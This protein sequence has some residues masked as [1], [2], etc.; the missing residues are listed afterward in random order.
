M[1][2]CTKCGQEQS[3]RRF[4]RNKGMK[5]G[6]LNHCK[7]CVSKSV[8]TAEQRE[9]KKIWQQSAEAKAINRQAQLKMKYGITLED[10]DDMLD[11]Q[12]GVC[13]ICGNP[14][15]GRR[16]AVDHNHE[17]GVF[18]GLLCNNCNRGI[19]H[20]KEDIKILKQAIKYLK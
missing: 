17:I 2:I 13:A 5:D 10:Y 19:G 1:K 7:S 18:R 15:T 16:L 3:L 12:G 6:R 8:N 20:L 14:P 11:E 9:Y 4:Y